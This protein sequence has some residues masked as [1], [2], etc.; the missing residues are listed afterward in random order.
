MFNLNE[1]V[2]VIRKSQKE[3][4]NNRKKYKLIKRDNDLYNLEKRNK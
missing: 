4:L 2:K 1:I 3:E